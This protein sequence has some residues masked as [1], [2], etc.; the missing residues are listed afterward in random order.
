MKSMKTTDYKKAGEII[1]KARF[2]KPGAGKKDALMT[3]FKDLDSL[4]GGFGKGEL[5][6]IAGRPSM[7]KTGFA[8]SLLKKVCIEGGKSCLYF[9]LKEDSLPLMERIIAFSSGIAVRSL[10]S[11]DDKE[12]AML[13]KSLKIIEKA[14]LY[15]NNSAYS[16]RGIIKTCR[17]L[18]R[19]SRID[20]VIIDYLQLISAKDKKK[21]ENSG[22][23]IVSSLK[24]LARQLKCPVVVLS[25]LNRKTETRK[26]HRP[27]L[28]DLK[29]SGKLNCYAD[30]ILFLYRDEY[31]DIDTERKGVTDVIVAKNTAGGPVGIVSLVHK[32]EGFLK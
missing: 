19:K 14:P 27:M 29:D 28:S 20:I 25:S 16:I 7:G 9:T 31:Y 13:K 22:E 23:Y 11:P 17:K 6:C 21:S 1:K 18:A 12:S 32:G 3:G 26:D 30:K 15:I 8:L 5:I 4:T 2:F 10:Y 24:L